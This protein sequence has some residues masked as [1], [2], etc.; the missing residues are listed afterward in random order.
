MD[1]KKPYIGCK[2][3]IAKPM[4]ENSF[5]RKF[6]KESVL[7]QNTR[8]GHLITYPDGSVSWLPEEVFFEAYRE[9]TKAEQMMFGVSL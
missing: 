8:E 4:D 6:N 7:N 1:D 5:L 3:I 2:I 9:V